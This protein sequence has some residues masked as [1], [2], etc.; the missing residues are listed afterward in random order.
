MEKLVN[1]SLE[2]SR[3]TPVFANDFITMNSDGENV[4][5]TVGTGKG[6]VALVRSSNKVLMIRT[7]RYATDSMEWALPRGSSL[8]YESGPE[9]AS[10]CVEGWT[11][12]TVDEGSII[13]LGEMYPDSEILTNEVSL[14]A[15]S[16]SSSKV[17]TNH[18]HAKWVD[19]EELVTACIEGEV[20]DSF[21]CIAMLR[22]R[23]L[24]I[25]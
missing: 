10:R 3:A 17:R 8:E 23:I 22:A 5:V 11:G 7:P 4:E 15:M 6:A 1:D 21:T 19:V 12:V 18:D 24:G 20:E 9:T 14:F 2:S 16:A 13:A 25:L